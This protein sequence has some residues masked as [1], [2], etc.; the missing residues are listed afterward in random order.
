MNVI[1]PLDG[2]PLFVLYRPEIV[3]CLNEMLDYW[4]KLAKEN[5]FEN[6]LLFAYQNIDFD[7]QKI[8][9]IVDLI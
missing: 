5:G 9:M 7:W 8:K 3:G 1:S 4:N 6:W 2:R